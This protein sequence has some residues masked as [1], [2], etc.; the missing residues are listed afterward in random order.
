MRK[1]IYFVLIEER[2]GKKHFVMTNASSLEENEKEFGGDATIR[3]VCG[4]ELEEDQQEMLNTLLRID[5]ATNTGLV[6]DLAASLFTAGYH[7]GR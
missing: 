7:F 6:V 1:K 3:A 2:N 4:V 5:H